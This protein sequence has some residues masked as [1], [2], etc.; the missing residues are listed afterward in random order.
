MGGIRMFAA[1]S[2]GFVCK[3]ADGNEVKE[4]SQ[5]ERSIVRK[6]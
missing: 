1:R 6:A 3:R 5:T 4:V 2:T